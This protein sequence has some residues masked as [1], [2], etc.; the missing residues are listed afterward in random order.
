[1]S[2][3]DLRSRLQSFEPGSFEYE[4]AFTVA[5][6]LNELLF[7]DLY[8]SNRFVVALS[9]GPDS[10]ALLVSAALGAERF[11]FT[12]SACHVNH[13][14]R[15]RES[16]EDQQFCERLCDALDVPID[17]R[18][19]EPHLSG[20]SEEE[21]REERYHLLSTAAQDFGVSFIAVGHT[22]D[23]QVETLLFRLFRG[24][25][26]SGLAGMRPLRELES[27]MFVARPMLQIRRRDC[28]RFL[29][30]VGIAARRDSS[31]DKDEYS[32]NYIRNIIIPTVQSRF[33]EFEER[34]ERMRLVL[35]HEDELLEALA[36]DSLESLEDGTNNAEQVWSRES[37]LALPIALQRRV[38]AL[39]MKH[40]GVEVTFERVEA[41]VDMI[42]T[43]SPQP[44]IGDTTH[45]AISLN[46]QWD[47]R[48]DERQIRW[49]DKE[50]AV[51]E[52][53]FKQI[54]TS[55][56]VKV[57]GLTLIPARGQALRVEPWEA[58]G[59]K[60]RYPEQTASEAL[61]DLSEVKLPIFVRDRRPG[62]VIRP[63][64]MSQLVR[65]KKYLHNRKQRH[66]R[67]VVVLADNEEVLWIPGVG[68]SDKIKVKSKPTHR[69]SILELSES[70]DLA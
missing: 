1:M 17:I 34:I 67:N 70:A 2:D 54:K 47:V 22:L 38:I 33:P 60:L 62:D 15:G 23:D 7:A 66:P 43:Y 24:S 26:M 45:G 59:E 25:A 37:F 53:R 28:E 29:A 31:N 39:A 27:D 61:V 3:S 20:T 69:L 9:G 68:L 16:D 58:N 10:T 46:A 19:A 32:R 41:I 35:Y 65:L 44:S 4:F 36:L 52:H 12:F 48:V 63:F 11:D 40:R 57:P 56:R 30:N 6:T 5:A 49:I 51:Y 50:V 64:G 13:K 55:I 18:T 21:L 8:K 14:L 42:D